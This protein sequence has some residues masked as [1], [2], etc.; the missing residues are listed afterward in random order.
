MIK[1]FYLFI[2]YTLLNFNLF[3]DE[4]SDKKLILKIDTIIICTL[5]VGILVYVGWYSII[6]TFRF[7]SHTFK[8]FIQTCTYIVYFSL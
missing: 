3:K 5:Y 1:V 7:S 4:Y 2:K 8:M 6:A